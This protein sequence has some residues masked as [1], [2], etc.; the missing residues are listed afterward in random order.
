MILINH[1]NPIIS[2]KLHINELLESY[3]QYIGLVEYIYL[4]VD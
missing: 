4:K 1:F 2:S 3:G